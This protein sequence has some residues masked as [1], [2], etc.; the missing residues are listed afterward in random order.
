MFALSAAAL[1]ALVR[2]CPPGLVRHCPPEGLGRPQLRH[3]LGQRLRH[4]AGQPAARFAA[5]AQGYQTVHLGGARGSPT[6]GLE[7]CP[8]HCVKARDARLRRA[9]TAGGGKAA[10]RG[11]ETV[12]RKAETHRAETRGPHVGCTS[13]AIHRDLA[14][15]GTSRSRCSTFIL[16]NDAPHLDIGLFFQRP[17]P[18]YTV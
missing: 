12:R 7:R 4:R 8:G 13:R 1:L 17:H 14:A 15:R 9:R 3:P 18:D 16:W 10:T 11:A 5:A 2:H 6:Q